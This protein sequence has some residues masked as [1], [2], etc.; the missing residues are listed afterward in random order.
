M[1]NDQPAAGTR[2][3][4][5]CKKYEVALAE[6]YSRAESAHRGELTTATHRDVLQGIL[7]L[8]ASVLNDVAGFEGLVAQIGPPEPVDFMFKKR[9]L[10]DWR[11]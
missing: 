9:T 11:E 3:C 8:T 5:R 4:R 1:E 6:I 7:E 10:S 2:R